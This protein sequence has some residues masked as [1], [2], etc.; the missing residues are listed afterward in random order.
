MAKLNVYSILDTVENVHAFRGLFFHGSDA[1]FIRTSMFSVLMD[2]PLRDIKV[3]HIGFFDDDTGKL[4]PCE[5]RI[6]DVSKCYKFPKDMRS[7]EG[8]DVSLEK[9]EKDAKEFKAKKIAQLTAEAEKI[10]K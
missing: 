4:E 9:V 6:V 7:P 1:S 3:V 10:K 2:Y 5:H 8:D